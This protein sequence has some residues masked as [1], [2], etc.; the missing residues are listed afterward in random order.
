MRARR[1]RSATAA[2]GQH[3]ASNDHEQAHATTAMDGH[4][5]A[6]GDPGLV[7]DGPKGRHETAAKARGGHEIDVLRQGR[8]DIIF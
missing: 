2:A 1:M 4:P 8:F 6:L 3:L 7:Y 5:L